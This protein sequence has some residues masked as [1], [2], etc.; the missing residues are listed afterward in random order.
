MHKIYKEKHTISYREC[1][2]IVNLLVAHTKIDRVKIKIKHIDFGFANLTW[3]RK[4][5]IFIPHDVIVYGEDAYIL[6]YI[7]H[8]V[9]HFVNCARYYRKWL[10]NRLPS[11][12][13]TF[14]EIERELCKQWGIEIIKYKKAYASKLEISGE[15][16]HMLDKSTFGDVNQL[17]GQ[18][19]KIPLQ[20]TPG[21]HNCRHVCSY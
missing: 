1:Q 5:Y 7:T 11:H 3:G 8:E 2:L 4:R 16:V 13:K 19:R 12:G 21:E 14:K 6:W 20:I 18:T 17:S 10:A 15:K 9:A